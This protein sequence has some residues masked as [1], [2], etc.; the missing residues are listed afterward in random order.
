MFGIVVGDEIAD[1][2]ERRC[3]IEGVGGH[4]LQE[5]RI[6]AGHGEQPV[7]QFIG[8]LFVAVEHPEIE[9]DGGVE[10]RFGVGLANPVAEL[11]APF[12]DGQA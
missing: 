7:A 12:F 10:Q 9:E 3:H 11:L 5:G 6:A 8:E 4:C 2:A 1:L